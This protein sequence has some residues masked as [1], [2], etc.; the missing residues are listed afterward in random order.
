MPSARNEVVCYNI[1]LVVL[2][3]IHYKLI[4]IEGRYSTH[5]ISQF[6]GVFTI[7]A[8]KATIKNPLT[9]YELKG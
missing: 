7:L 3:H 1:S 5:L 2:E 9:H 6:Q 8:G 4:L